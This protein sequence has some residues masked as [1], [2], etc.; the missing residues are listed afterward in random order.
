MKDLR[1]IFE[2]RV[3]PNFFPHERALMEVA[4]SK[5][6]YDSNVLPMTKTTRADFIKSVVEGI[7]KQQ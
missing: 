1:L 3:A 7:C 5:A 4:I 6:E 2:E